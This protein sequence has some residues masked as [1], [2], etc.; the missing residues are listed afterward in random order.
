MRNI[1]ID[2]SLRQESRTIAGRQDACRS[3]CGENGC[4]GGFEPGITQTKFYQKQAAERCALKQS[5]FPQKTR[6][7]AA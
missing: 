6:G 7:G 1:S 5:A 2:S 4:L 3:S